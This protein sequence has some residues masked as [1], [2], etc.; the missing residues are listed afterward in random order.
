MGFFSP[1]PNSKWKVSQTVPVK[2]ALAG[3]NGVRLSD[4]AAAALVTPGNCRVKISAGPAV[5]VTPTCVRYDAVNHQFVFNLKL[6]TRGS[7]TVTITV[8]YPNTSSTTNKSVSFT[9][10]K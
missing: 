3:S 2:F 5:T 9:I 7:E 4:A 6:T 10:T 1:V 8:S